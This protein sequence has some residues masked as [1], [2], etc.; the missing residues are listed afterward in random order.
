MKQQDE[1]A[2]EASTKGLLEFSNLLSTSNKVSAK[3]TY[4][5]VE[6]IKAFEYAVKVMDESAQNAKFS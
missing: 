5:A 4:R 3:E 2:G 6:M 1:L